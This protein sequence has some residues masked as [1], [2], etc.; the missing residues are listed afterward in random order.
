MTSAAYVDGRAARKAATR[1]AIADALLDLLR[2]GN[3]RPRAK[4]IAARAGTSVRSLYVHFDDL[5]DLFW[6]AARRHV[7]RIRALL[8][9][10]PATGTLEARARAVMAQRGR[11]HEQ[12]GPVG[13]AARIQAPSSP[14]LSHE[15]AR[16]RRVSRSDLERVFAPELDRLDP[17]TREARLAVLEVL[18]GFDSWDHLR[19]QSRL[20][21]AD[22]CAAAEHAIVGLLRGAPA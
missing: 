6:V 15:M 17:Q 11:I 7:E 18:T 21:V 19:T 14:T 2:E 20:D 4:E 16:V 10:V 9:P 13:R 1:D 8:E 22:A 12:V 5:E 3:L